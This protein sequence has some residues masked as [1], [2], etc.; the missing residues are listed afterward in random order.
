MR[1]KRSFGFQDF[2]T[3]QLVPQN[4]TARG[5]TR[6]Y[7]TLNAPHLVQAMRDQF[8][9]HFPLRSG[10][11][12]LKGSPIRRAGCRGWESHRKMLINRSG[13]GLG[14]LEVASERYHC[15]LPHPIVMISWSVR[16]TSLDVWLRDYHSTQDIIFFTIRSK[17]LS[18]STC[19]VFFRGVNSSVRNIAHQDDTH[20]RLA[21]TV[22]HGDRQQMLNNLRLEYPTLRPFSHVPRKRAGVVAPQRTKTN[23]RHHLPVHHSESGCCT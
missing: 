10:E 16:K 15:K 3:C 11:T 21:L 13:Y 20:T 5:S 6:Q 2:K 7:S 18:F 4:N 23:A 17:R 19:G 9:Q 22:D 14:I 12:R 8:L 1:S